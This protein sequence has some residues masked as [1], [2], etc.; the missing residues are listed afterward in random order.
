MDFDKDYMNTHGYGRYEQLDI[1]L[2]PPLYL[3]Y[4]HLEHK[5][6]WV[7]RPI[8][9]RWLSQDPHTV[10]TMATLADITQRGRGALLV[11]DYDEFGR[12]MNRNFDTRLSLYG[13]E[14]IGQ[15]SMRMVGIAREMGL[16]AKL[17]GSGGAV[18]GICHPSGLEPVALRFNEEGFGCCQVEP[19]LTMDAV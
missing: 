8:R 15:R 12:L 10:E 5:S 14:L 11:R 4:D 7:H 13:E 9:Q 17:A 18:V 6:G 16:C 3:A 2:L 19:S 1:S